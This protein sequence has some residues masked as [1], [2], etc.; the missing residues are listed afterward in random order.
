MSEQ[1]TWTPCRQ[2]H[3]R[4]R[5]EQSA[6]GHESPSRLPHKGKDLN[7]WPLNVCSCH[8]PVCGEVSQG[9]GS[10]VTHR[11][12]R[13]WAVVS[14]S[15]ICLVLLAFNGR[16]T[17]VVSTCDFV[18]DPSALFCLSPCPP[19]PCPSSSRG[20]WVP[21]GPCRRLS[22]ALGLQEQ[23]ERSLWPAPRRPA[24]RSWCGAGQ[25]L[26][27]HC[28]PGTRVRQPCRWRLAGWRFSATLGPGPCDFTSHVRW[29]VF[30][31]F[32]RPPAALR[33]RCLGRRPLAP[34]RPS[35]GCCAEQRGWEVVLGVPQGVCSAR[36]LTGVLVCP[37]G[38]SPA[39]ACWGRM[40]WQ[41][42]FIS[43]F[44]GAG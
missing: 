41:G 32:N 31:L 9:H 42:V 10:M 28:R 29:C 13:P 34:R 11:H 20:D 27:P 16:A 2:A 40:L 7:V 19:A 43:L 8:R 5:G 26:G 17:A 6:V 24:A 4:C 21:A 36:G 18:L 44:G 12:A 15:R 37:R 30:G 22:W 39:A 3:L 35:E 38:E 23:V 14:T 1:S 33:L 25:L